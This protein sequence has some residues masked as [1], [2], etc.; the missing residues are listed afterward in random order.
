M[1]I[2]SDVFGIGINTM[3]FCEAVAIKLNLRLSSN[4]KSSGTFCPS[5]KF[6]AGLAKPKDHVN[7][8]PTEIRKWTPLL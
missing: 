8:L 6:Q 2:K 7:V 5:V 3:S 4:T 1:F